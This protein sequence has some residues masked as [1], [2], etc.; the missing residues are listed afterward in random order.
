MKNTR[1]YFFKKDPKSTS[2]LVERSAMGK[3]QCVYSEGRKEK[4][5]HTH[6]QFAIVNMDTA[7]G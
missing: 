1:E 3:Q 4:W 6:N 5:Q 7:P 2:L